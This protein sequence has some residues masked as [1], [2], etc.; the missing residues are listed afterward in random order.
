M[1]RKVKISVADPDP[2]SG[3]FLTP[4]SEIRDPV[5]T[6]SGSLI[7]GSKRHL[8]PDPGSVTLV[9]VMS[10]SAFRNGLDPDSHSQNA[11]THA[12]KNT[13]TSFFHD[14]HCQRRN[15][16]FSGTTDS[17]MLPFCSNLSSALFSTTAST[18]AGV[19]FCFLAFC[20][21]LS[22]SLF[23]TTAS[24]LAECYLL[25]HSVLL[26]PLQRSILHH[27]LHTSRM[28]PFVS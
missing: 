10:C 21:S 14:P 12:V 2:G 20:L 5:K 17:W 22:S 26:V 7:P 16:T 18:L 23:S 9:S 1:K 11:L 6:Y 19:T 24:T 3:A 13:G 28:L 27:S 25:F 8:I 4:R 15:V